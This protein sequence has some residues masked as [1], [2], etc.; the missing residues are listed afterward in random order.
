MTLQQ[1]REAVAEGIGT[2]MLVLVAA[3]TVAVV[4]GNVIA[5]ALAYG[6]IL[7]AIIATYG[8]IS[9]AHVNPAVTLGLLVGGKMELNRAVIYWVSQLIG[10][11]L[12]AVV[13]R[14]VLDNQPGVT[15][16]GQT[17]PANGINAL[18]IILIEGILTFF[19]VST[20]YQA[21]IYG[22][23][24]TVAPILIGFTLAGATL[25]GGTLTGASLNPA[26]TIGPALFAKETQD[27]IEVGNYLIGILLGAT[28]AGFLHTD[29]FA[30]DDDDSS[31]KK[32]RSKKR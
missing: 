32:S 31:G 7:V 23:G 1:T 19:L 24:G 29:T 15:T 25:F 21:A 18:H 5:A 2:F 16:L 3:G 28:L 26:R 22:K 10:G 6:L 27:L 8:H 13:L 17:A 12:A 9:G 14:I 30:Q 4:P 20:V 11:L